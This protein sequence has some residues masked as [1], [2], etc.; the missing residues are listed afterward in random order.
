MIEEVFVG[1]RFLSSSFTLLLFSTDESV[2]GVA[3]L[4]LFF[5]FFEEESD[6]ALFISL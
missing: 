2:D 4:L 5:F 6:I 1:A 3:M